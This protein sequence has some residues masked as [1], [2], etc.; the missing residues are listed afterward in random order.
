MLGALCELCQGGQ[1]KRKDG[2]YRNNAGF[3]P[4]MELVWR[5]SEWDDNFNPANPSGHYYVQ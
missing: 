2:T 3:K 1:C 4:K 5:L